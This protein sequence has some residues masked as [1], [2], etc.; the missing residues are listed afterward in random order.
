MPLPAARRS[1]PARVQGLGDALNLPHDRDH[2]GR[3]L[4]GAV[5]NFSYRLLARLA[6]LWVA[7]RNATRLSGC[8]GFRG[9]LADKGK[10]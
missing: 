8:Q 3:A 6:D 10:R 2:I 5:N 4:V 1:D 7:E 9:A